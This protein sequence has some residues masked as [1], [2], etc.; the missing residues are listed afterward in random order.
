MGNATFFL[1][2]PQYNWLAATLPGPVTKTKQAIPDAE[3]LNGILFVPKTGCRWQDV[4]ASICNHGYSSCW[5]RLRFWCT[6]G[7]LKLTWQRVLIILDQ[8]SKLDGTL[9]QAPKFA[10]TGYDSQHS[11]YGT[12]ISLLTERHGLPLTN[13]TS[14]GNRN[15][16]VCAEATINK[17]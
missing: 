5:R 4:P 12:N 2:Q 7:Q 9:V 3:L 14:K 10:G 8:E 1:S 16:I 11:R 15:D 17:V 6:R 13:M